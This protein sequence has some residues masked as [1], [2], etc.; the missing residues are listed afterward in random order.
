MASELSVKGNVAYACSLLLFGM[1]AAVINA[2]VIVTFISYR[3]QIFRRKSNRILFSMALADFMVGLFFFSFGN[4][5]ILNQNTRI[6]RLLAT[7]PLFGSMFVSIFSMALLTADRLV[8]VRFPLKYLFIVTTSRLRSIIIVSWVVPLLLTLQQ[9]FIL[10]YCS[11]KS[12]LRIR[13]TV[14]VVFTV[15]GSV[16]LAAANLFLYRDVKKQSKKMRDASKSLCNHDVK[17]SPVDK[18]EENLHFQE[19]ENA[20]D[21]NRDP[22]TCRKKRVAQVHEARVR[23][24][25]LTVSKECIIIIF[26]FISCWL[27]LTAYRLYY[28]AFKA[29]KM[30]D[31]I[32]TFHILASFSSIF[33]PYVYFFRKKQ[34][35][36]YLRRTKR[37]FNESSCSGRA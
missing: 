3:R 16:F 14:L 29:L 7:I 25:E 33:N 22:K 37:S 4:C 2:V 17:E 11:S 19:S 35:R 10:V 28:S 21:E 30:T 1:C 13:G 5:M 12:E 31:M 26:V 27:P 32:R 24:K 36:N 9:C 15:I 34:F 18:E 20:Q 6:L 23:K 8:A